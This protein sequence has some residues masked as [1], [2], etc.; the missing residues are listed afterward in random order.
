M[1]ARGAL[2]TAIVAIF[3]AAP[4]WAHPAPG[5]DLPAFDY[6]VL[7]LSWSP[8]FCAAHPD[9]RAQCS[10]RR[11]F[12]AHGLWPEYANGGGPEHCGSDEVPGR[13]TIERTLS[14]MPDERL[15]RHEWVVHGACSGLS[16]HDYFVSLIRAVGSLSIPGEFDGATTQRLSADEIAGKFLGANPALQ[17]RS[18]VLRCKGEQFEELRVCLSPELKPVA[19]GRG[20][21]SQCR[22]GPLLIRAAPSQ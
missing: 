4:A 8:A 7:S 3:A 19:C 20:V 13:E 16:A 2:A 1:N 14:A 17:R 10:Q 5:G 9:D 11:G 22:K 6:F 15:I 18:L 12:V 21:H